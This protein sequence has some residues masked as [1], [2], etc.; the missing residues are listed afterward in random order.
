MPYP[1]TQEEKDRMNELNLRANKV[2]YGVHISRKEMEIGWFNIVKFPPDD[3][4]YE[5]SIERPASPCTD[6][7]E[8]GAFIVQK[9]KEIAG[10]S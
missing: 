4:D 5:S 6:L 3:F 2:G 1:F 9:E 10:G 7:D 8:V